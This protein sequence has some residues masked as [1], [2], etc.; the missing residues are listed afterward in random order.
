MSLA[1]AQYL[2]TVRTETPVDG[3]GAWQKHQV[4]QLENSEYRDALLDLR[5]WTSVA[6]TAQIN[7][8]NDISNK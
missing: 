2:N 3:T 1:L 8:R 6:F 5:A 7:N 4:E